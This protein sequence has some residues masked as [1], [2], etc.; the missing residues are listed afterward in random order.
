MKLTET[1]FFR[2]FPYCFFAI[3][4]L[5]LLITCL[6]AC[7]DIPRE[8]IP[9]APEKSIY[10]SK[11]RKAEIGFPGHQKCSIF[12]SDSGDL[13][14]LLP[15][16]HGLLQSV[17]I[18]NGKTW[19]APERIFAQPKPGYPAITG[20]RLVGIF[21][22][23]KVANGG[24]LYF[25]RRQGQG[26]SAA[27]P[28]RDTNW[29]DFGTGGSLA[30]D[31]SGNLYCAWIDERE[32]NPDV[33]VSS[34]NDAGKTW[35]TNIRV[36]DDQSGQE[37]GYCSLLASPRG[38]LYALW[39]DNRNPGT[40]FDIYCASSSDGGKTWSRNVK[41][42][43][44]SSH[45]WQRFP[46]V[47]L[48]QNGNLSVAWQD[49]REKGVHHDAIAN[50]YFARSTDGGK[51]WSRNIRIS[52]AKTGHNMLPKLVLDRDGSLYCAWQSLDENQFADVYFSRSRDNGQS[53][54]Q[55][56]RVNDD[57]ALA[58]HDHRN[59]GPLPELKGN[60]FVGW[61][62]WRDGRPAVYLAKMLDQPDSTRPERR[63]DAAKN[64]NKPGPVLSF[65]PGK[66]VFQ[67]DF[68]DGISRQWRVQ[69]GNWV[70]KERMLIGYGDAR[71]VID[72][73][74]GADFMFSGQFLLDPLNHRAALVLWGAGLANSA[75][76]GF[77]RV[78]NMFRQGVVLEY[79][80]GTSFVH[81]AEV[82]YPFQENAW[83][84]FRLAVKG[85]ALNYFIDDSLILAADKLTRKAGGKVGLGA[86]G[87]PVYFKKIRIIEIH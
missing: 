25:H 19:A 22:H 68:A 42:N 83:Y 7:N 79:F 1:P 17:S 82:P 60:V 76:R 59:A 57:L 29:G 40:L 56:A 75:R 21:T 63:P 18:D 15:T 51:S 50:V 70:W 66:I 14:A 23:A 12:R 20:Q 8:N 39:D 86:M 5:I 43:D 67:D 4:S 3:A 80:D 53:W 77:Y 9:S 81:L 48:D 28:I 55:P 71:S 41:V 64:R 32:G 73:S 10:F 58:R 85:D 78:T 24:Q 13:I 62:D 72:S 84:S 87:P 35:R 26:W 27:K 38:T 36:N 33:Y 37:Q 16:E 69:S 45:T 31:S 2:K 52:H 34:S 65:E 30:I 47:V 44:D 61:L 6:Q 11:N 46:C 49:F 54:S 74:P